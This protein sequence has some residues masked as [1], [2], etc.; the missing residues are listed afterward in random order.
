MGGITSKYTPPSTLEFFIPGN[1]KAVGLLEAAERT[2]KYQTRCA[3]QPLNVIARKDYIYRPILTFKDAQL[4]SFTWTIPQ[5][6]KRDLAG[7]IPVIVL[8]PTAEGGMPHTRAG[9]ILCFPGTNNMPNSTTMCH[10]LVHIHQRKYPAKWAAFYKDAFDFEIWSGTIPD[11]LDNR[12][13]INPDTIEMPNWIWRGR[14]VPV[15]VFLRPEEPTLR[16]MRVHFYDA[17]DH[18]WTSIPPREWFGFFGDSLSESEKEH[19]HELA[20]YWISTYDNKIKGCIAFTLFQR[21][22]KKWFIGGY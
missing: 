18:T 2:D 14:W 19:P 15:P 4:L 11:E 16:G 21:A 13:R 9:G 8:D 1:L 7:Q 22:M 3:A 17:V 5:W 20:A 12:R 10:E 6:L